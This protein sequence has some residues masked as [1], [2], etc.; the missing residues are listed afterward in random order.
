M[1]VDPIVAA[2][3]IT[4]AVAA[5]FTAARLPA[6]IPA[7]SAASITEATRGHFPLAAGQALAEAS[8][9][10]EVTAEEVTDENGVQDNGQ[11]I[12]GV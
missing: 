7:R 1:V 3:I 12:Q 10:V 5:S 4:P 6:R 2:H 11:T 8:M 9:V